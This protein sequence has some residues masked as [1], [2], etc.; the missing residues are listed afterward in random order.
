[1]QLVPQRHHVGLKLGHIAAKAVLK[2]HFSPS[3]SVGVSACPM[4]R[5]GGCQLSTYQG[6]AEPGSGGLAR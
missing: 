4:R 3:V 1:M 5:H 6:E 2:S